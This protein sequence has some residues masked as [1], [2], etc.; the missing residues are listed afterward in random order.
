MRQNV[1]KMLK[2]GRNLG[3]T[4]VW[5]DQSMN[6]LHS[7]G[8]VGIRFADYVFSGPVPLDRFSLPPRSVGL[9]V[10]LMPDST[11]GPWHLQPLFFG[12]FGPERGVRMSQSQQTCCLRVAAGRSLYYALYAVPHQHAWAASEILKEL[13]ARYRP[14]ANLEN[15]DTTADLT[16][17]L[18]ILEKKMIE[19]DLV[20]KLALAALGQTVQLQQPEPKKRI[21]GFQPSP[22]GSR[23]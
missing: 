3:L 2:P 12:Q 15:I 9:Y 1:N 5:L 13:V 7:R 10:V 11:W 17:R 8:L 23:R 4:G 22:A 16:Q 21:V 6:R 20:L 18:D 19:Q 14:I